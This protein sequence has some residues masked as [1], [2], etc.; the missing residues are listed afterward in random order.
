MEAGVKIYEYT[1]GFIHEKLVVSDDVYTVIGSINFDY[2]SLAHH[3][4]CAVWAY[5]SELAER[6]RDGVMD[7]VSKSKQMDSTAS[8]LTFT[9]WILK[10]IVRFFAPL[11]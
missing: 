3:F 5:S 10:N 2:R 1:P 4:E 8:R 11:L 6:A 9:E 7:T